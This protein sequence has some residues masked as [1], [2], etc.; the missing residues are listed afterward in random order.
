MRK[1][2]VFGQVMLVLLFMISS[3]VSAQI[4]NNSSGHHLFS[5]SNALQ[6]DMRMNTFRYNSEPGVSMN[7]LRLSD[8]KQPVYETD[9]YVVQLLMAELGGALGVAAGLAID[10]NQFINNRDTDVGG[11]FLTVFAGYALGI[12]GG[13]HV[14]G[15]IAKKNRSFLWALGGSVLGTG[16][17]MVALETADSNL[18]VVLTYVLPTAFS[19]LAYNLGPV[20]SEKS[21]SIG[22]VG[23]FRDS[24]GGPGVKMDLLSYRF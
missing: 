22:Q 19:M 17:A 10:G 7:A 1:E 9:Y 14:T 2:I 11:L 18:G 13:V 15:L 20:K 16:I 21:V 4:Q 8:M 6:N 23:Y 3:L 5:R 24:C 12:A